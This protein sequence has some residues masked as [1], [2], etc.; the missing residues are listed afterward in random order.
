MKI[1]EMKVTP[2]AFVAPPLLS[3]LGLHAPYALRTIIEIVTDDGLVGLSETHGGAAVLRD[4]ELARPRVIGMPPA[5]LTR[6]ETALTPDEPASIE[7]RAG[8]KL[9]S[10]AMTFGA[11]E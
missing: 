4:L 6:L 8:G 9:N 11:I 7:Y 5:R 2:C 1:I 10:P 3:A